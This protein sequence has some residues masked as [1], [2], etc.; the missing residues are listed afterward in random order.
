MPRG[1]VGASRRMAVIEAGS[2]DMTT[3]G[4]V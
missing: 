2:N 4:P 1:N 3:A